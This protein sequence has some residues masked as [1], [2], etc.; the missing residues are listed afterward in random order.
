MHRIKKLFYASSIVR[1]ALIVVYLTASIALVCYFIAGSRSAVYANTPT[2]RETTLPSAIPWG[3]SFDAT[4]NAWVAEPG[5]DPAPT[6]SPQQV[7]GDIAQYNRQSFTLVHNYAEPTGYSA[8]LFLTVD[9]TGTIWFTEPTTNAIGALTPDGGTGIWH[10][11]TVPT[12]SAAPYDLTFDKAGNLWYTELNAS[13]IGEFTPSTAL[14]AETATPTAQSSPYGIVGPDSDGSI[15]FTENNSAVSQIG[16]FTPPSS[17]TLNT[18]D[19]SEYM[20][21]ASNNSTPH[22]LAFDNKGTI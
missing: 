21:K 10:Q 1:V 18:S 3:I 5:C 12:L 17:G 15:W 7:P 4:G 9:S 20:T 8:P 22:L 14:F 2:I 11:W 6:C 16:R 19:I 13:Q